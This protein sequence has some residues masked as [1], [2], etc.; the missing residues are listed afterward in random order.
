MALTP[1]KAFNNQNTGIN[2]GTWG[3]V[4]NSNFTAIDQSFGGRKNANVAGAANVTVSAA[5][6]LNVFHLL[7]GLLTGNIEYILPATGAFYFIQNN[8]TGAFTV[9]VIVAGGTSSF[10]IPQGQTAFVFA[11]PD[12]LVPTGFINT[13]FLG[14]TTAGSANVQTLAAVTP[15][16]WSLIAGNILYCTA[17]FTNTLTATFQGPDGVAKNLRK[18]SSS[19]LIALTGGEII[20]NTPIAL[21]YDGAQ[22]ALLNPTAVAGQIPGTATNDNAAAGNIGEYIPSTVLIGAAVALVSNVAKTIT[23]IPLTA[24]DWDVSG[25]IVT[26]PAGGTTTAV[27][28][29]AISQADNTLP[30]SPAGGGIQQLIFN[31]AA[32]NSGALSAGTVRIS[33]AEPATI[34]LVADIVFGGGTLSAYGF[35][36]A[37]RAR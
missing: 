35:I 6:A 28:T 22:Y 11:D 19:G 1:N 30:T 15:G 37:R 7:T 17:G 23:S 18:N 36:G 10:I 9:T 2:S 12:N 3:I 8:T 20:A 27:L 16:P 34:Y 33:L 26:A 14:G 5:D 32:G 29:A 24:G 31:T 13:V 4:L 25:N 21:Y